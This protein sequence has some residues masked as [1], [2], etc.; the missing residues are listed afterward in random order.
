LTHVYW[1]YDAIAQGYPGYTLSDI[2]SMSIRQRSFWAAM[3][4]WRS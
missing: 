3:A 4:K 2:R 1:N